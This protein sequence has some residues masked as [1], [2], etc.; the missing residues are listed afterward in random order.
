MFHNIYVAIFAAGIAN[1]AG[2]TL[3]YSDYAFGALWK[4]L[5]G[6]MAAPKDTPKN[7]LLHTIASMLTASALYI[8]ISVFAKTQTGSYAQEGFFRIFSFFLSNATPTTTLNAAMKT[9]GFIWLGFLV[10]SKAVCAIWGSESW[11]KF[12]IEIAGQLVGFV[13]MAAVLAT[14]S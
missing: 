5:G 1:V 13:G 9:A 12:I 7:I 11:M 8:A 10:P 3:W 14:L 6:K 4:K 2:A